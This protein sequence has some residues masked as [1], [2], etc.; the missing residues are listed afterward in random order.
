MHLNPKGPP[1]F[2]CCICHEWITDEFGNNPYPIVDDETSS[3]CNM[4]DADVIM[5]RLKQQREQK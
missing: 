4:C 5:A 2:R 1:P 3:C